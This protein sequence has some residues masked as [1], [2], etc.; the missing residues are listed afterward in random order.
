MA[1]TGAIFECNSN[2]LCFEPT[3][4]TL[5]PGETRES[6]NNYRNEP[7]LPEDMQN[8]VNEANAQDMTGYGGDFDVDQAYYDMKDKQ[9]EEEQ[10]KKDTGSVY[11]EPDDEY[12]S[13]KDIPQADAEE[14]FGKI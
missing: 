10:K 7:K 9:H 13:N 11:D 5:K 2:A 12:V 3:P 8:F 1:P 6:L 4:G 14:L